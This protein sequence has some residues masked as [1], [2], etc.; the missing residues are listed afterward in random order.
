M[1]AARQR[2]LIERAKAG[3]RGAFGALYSA[4]AKELYAVAYYTMRTRE[5]AEDA[6]SE[7]AVDAFRSIG[8]LRDPDRFRMW[9]GKILSAKLKRGMKAYYRA[10]PPADEAFSPFPARD[11]AVALRAALE[12]LPEKSREIVILSA[13]YGYSSDEIERITGC[14]A[15]TV[16]TRLSRALQRLRDQ[17]ASGDAD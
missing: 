8:N 15:S 13:V 6:V 7:T 12:A 4:V 11:E 9:I 3:D 17:L 1:D 14:K 5:D 16:R 10:G 2:E